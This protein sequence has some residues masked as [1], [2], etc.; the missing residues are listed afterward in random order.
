M[1]KIIL[2]FVCLV[3]NLI[4]SAQTPVANAGEDADFCGYTGILNAIPS[5]GTGLWTTPDLEHITISEPNNP[6]SEVISNIINTWDTEHIGFE[7][8]WTETSGTETDSDTILVN[9][10]EQPQAYA[11]V[12]SAV[13]GNTY[14]LGAVFDISETDNYSPS[15]VWSVY[16]KPVPAAQTNIQP[17]NN[18]TAMCTVSHYGI[19]QY[20]F[21]DINTNLPSCYD[22]DTVLIEFL[23]IPVVYAGED[24]D[25][26][27][28]CTELEAISGGYNGSWL[29]N[30]ST[31]E[32][33]EDPNTIVCQSTYGSVEYIWFESNQAWT[34][35]TFACSSEDTVIIT[36][37]RIPTATILTDEADSTTC[38]LTF[39][40][41][42]AENPGS[43]I[44]GY[45]WS[46]SAQIEY[47][48]GQ[49][50]CT[51]IA[52]QYGHLDFYWIEETG[53]SYYPDFC[54]DTAGPLT[55]HFIEMPVAN[56]GSDTLF[57]GFS[58]NLNAI[59]SVGTGVWGSPS[60]SNFS[61]DGINDP[62]TLITSNI[63]NA[64]NPSYPYFNLIW[65]EDNTNGCTDSDTIKVIFARTPNSNINIIPPKCFGEPASIAAD[66]DSLQNYYWNFYSG[67]IDSTTINPLGGQ[68]ENFVHWNST[69]T[70]HRISLITTNYWN[71]QSMIT[72][73]TVYEPAIPEFNVTIVAD[74][75]MLNKGAIIFGDTLLSNSFF[76]LD[77]DYGPPVES[78]ITAIYNLPTGEYY[79]RTSYPT[80][81]MIYYSYYLATFNNTSC[82]DTIPYTIEPIGMIEAHIEVSVA[83][84][85][86]E[87]VVPTAHVIFVNN[88]V[89][90]SIYDDDSERCEWHFGDATT[91]QNCDAQIEHYY[92]EADCF[93][94][95]LIIMNI[96]MPACRDT[97]FISPCINVTDNNGV[98][99]NDFNTLNFSIFPNPA[100]ESFSV[101][102]DNAKP[103][104]V[105]VI[106]LNGKIVLK[107]PN[108]CGEEINIK[109]LI[110]G[111]YFVKIQ[112]SETTECKKL[113]VE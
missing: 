7:L 65:T 113:F 106:D 99:E 3:A 88:S 20:I 92:T 91:L 27:G 52:P 22:T 59:P 23:E 108:Y 66:E 51:A 73:D 77:T 87:L 70:L 101:L 109:N 8:I 83:T 28:S 46:P 47:D 76:W 94:P 75:C 86:N 102:C 24:K 104:G 36:Y 19:Y 31:C 90:N 26:C 112:S 105:S 58:G 55:I 80:P 89:Y 50:N 54:T 21:I 14:Q 98:N 67:I 35:P 37:W 15:G 33:Y 34:N 13:C 63:L 17:Q 38:G 84:N 74:T 5:V 30:G 2:L 29:A 107:I 25:V 95:F 56:A 64:E 53:P 1:K 18:D 81:N 96:D 93:N 79:I 9:F 68:Y 12:D 49:P 44:T 111:I 11:G 16:Q 60:A 57:C 72:I 45:W 39:D 82:I 6:N 103:M 78:P 43:G 62:N 41:L 42:R 69:D 32:D 10:Y 71:C 48:Y 97:A 100:K 4:I 85:L 61:I 40:R 110:R